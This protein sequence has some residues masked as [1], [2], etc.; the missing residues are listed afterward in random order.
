MPSI[1]VASDICDSAVRRRA[2]HCALSDRGSVSACPRL[3]EQ[4]MCTVMADERS[5]DNLPVRG[6]TYRVSANVIDASAPRTASTS[7]SGVS[8]K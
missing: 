5:V 3:P 7:S 2:S 8:G 4:S 1:W 6:L